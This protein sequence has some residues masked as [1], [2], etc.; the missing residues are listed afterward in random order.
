MFPCTH[1]KHRYHSTMEDGN[2]LYGLEVTH[3]GNALLLFVVGQHVVDTAESTLKS[4]A[5]HRLCV[6]RVLLVVGLGAFI[7][8]ETPLVAEKI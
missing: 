8:D 2:N 4:E 5:N 6:V 3:E 7:L 1:A